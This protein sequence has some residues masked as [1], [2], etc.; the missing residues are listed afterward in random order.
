MT[1]E[2]LAPAGGMPQLKAAVQSG[3]DAVYIGGGSFNARR[4]A[5]NFTAEE[6]K[7]AVDY[8]HLYGVK[9][10]V[11]VNTL[12]K[13]RELEGL[14]EYAGSLNDMGV[15]ALII[16]D[17][18]AAK[19]IH[20]AFPD[21]ELHASTQMTVTSLEGVR[22]LEE[23]GF[24][25]VVLARELSKDEIEYIC[26]HAK[27]EIE[28]FVHGAICQCY[29]GQCL[30]SSILGGRSGNRGACAQPCRLKYSIGTKASGY[31]LSPKDMAL[32]NELEELRR[33]GVSSLKIE[34]RLKR[35]EYVSAV[36]GI[37]R[38]Y[39][40]F[41]KKV[42]HEDLTELKNAFSRTGFT[43]GYFQNKLGSAMMS[44]SDPSNCENSFTAEAVSRT[45]DNANFRKIPIS[46][47]ASLTE[48]KPLY[49]S[50]CDKDGH[51]TEHFGDTAEKAVSRPLDANRLKEQ[52]LKLGSTPFKANE[53]NITLDEGITVPI[54]SINSTRREAADE[55]MRLRTRTPKRRRCDFAFPSVVRNRP[56]ISLTASVRNAEQAK[57][58]I[59]LGIETI[60][61]PPQLAD[62]LSGAK[63]IADT[64][65]I[66]KK[67][68]VKCDEVLV[69]SN[70]A[71]YYYKEK[72]LHGDFRLNVFNSLTAQHYSDFKSVTLSP[73][74]NI[75]EIG[76]LLRNTDICAEIIAY[77]RIPLMI[78]KN[79]PLK[80]AGHC[81]NHR[82]LHTLKDRKNEE[83]PILCGRD[84]VCELINSKPIYMADKLSELTRLP[85]NYLRLFFT[86]EN[87]AEC[88]EIAREYITALNGGQAENPFGENEFTRGHF[89]RGVK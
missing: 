25:R 48:G 52:L 15:D 6:M 81:Q 33:M 7:E 28:V 74:L 17:I 68:S 19:M 35:A 40:D 89:F 5:K 8:C 80:A 1:P 85:V 24:S 69:A 29:S 77:G 83:F 73:E 86:I 46:I 62:N 32:I 10:H 11:A 43:D 60:Y 51:F 20:A 26:R 76:A 87:A 58:L 61:A 71:A 14:L 49:I 64:G 45:A 84:C 27:A 30:M 54:R 13:E 18:G 34:G 12:I 44:S 59:S 9:I 21:T 41:P 38:K 53:V 56:K 67:E 4:S 37:Y 23:M 50:I 47:S 66:F 36:T 55:L 2:L 63:I 3:A 88:E 72:T 70:A 78:M 79:C 16:Q 82:Q 22:Y 31:L 42:S 75:G 39:L 57:A 65:S